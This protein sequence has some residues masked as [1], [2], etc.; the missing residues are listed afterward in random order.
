MNEY[1]ETEIRLALK[2]YI[3]QMEIVSRS[4]L[5]ITRRELDAWNDLLFVLN[6]DDP[7]KLSDIFIDHT[8][9][10]DD[11]ENQEAISYRAYEPKKA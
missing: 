10:Q 3:H 9:G 1:R 11:G 7:E 8:R 6:A 4:R 5:E 2:D